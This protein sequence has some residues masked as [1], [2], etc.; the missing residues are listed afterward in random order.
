MLTM[1]EIDNNRDRFMSLISEL[2]Q[3]LGVAEGSLDTLKEYLDKS[4]FYFAPASTQ[5]AYSYEGGRC[6]HC[7]NV[8]DI[9]CKLNEMN[10]DFSKVMIPKV[11]IMITSLFHDLYKINYYE[12]YIK[13]EKVYSDDGKKSDELG[14]FDWVSKK[15]FGIKDVSKRYTVGDGGIT[16]YTILTRFLLIEPNEAAAIINHT[17]GMDKL[18]NDSRT[19]EVIAKYP[20]ATLL[21][22]ADYLSTFYYPNVEH[23]DYP[24]EEEVEEESTE[25]VKEDSDKDV[26]DLPF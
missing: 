13:N 7:L 4:D 19:T 23:F 5:Y 16:S 3:E 21:H 25:E 15:V 9:M 18:V 22:T 14:R 2:E 6:E 26:D 1:T 10:K 8:Y 20:I 17:S 12:E 11:S 24:V